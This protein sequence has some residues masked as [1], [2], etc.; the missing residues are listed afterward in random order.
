MGLA[1]MALPCPQY[2]RDFQKRLNNFN[3]QFEE[4]HFLD[5]AGRR[6]LETFQQSGIDQL[7]YP[8]FQAEVRGAGAKLQPVR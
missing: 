6:D 4:I 7:D 8:T 5:G 1:V 2:T 3:L